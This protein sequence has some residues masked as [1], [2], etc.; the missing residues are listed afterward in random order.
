[1]EGTGDEEGAV[2]AERTWSVEKGRAIFWGPV[3]SR[4]G[5]VPC[6]LRSEMLNSE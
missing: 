1:M 6:F 4:L 3:E 5:R 2:T